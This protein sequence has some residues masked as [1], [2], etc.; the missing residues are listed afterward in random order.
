MI[1]NS[2]MIQYA[3]LELIAKSNL[4]L[5]N[6]VNKFFFLISFLFFKIQDKM[7]RCMWPPLTRRFIPITKIIFVRKKHNIIYYSFI[8]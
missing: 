7:N 8:M 1:I 6:W 4:T 5:V 2:D 3:I